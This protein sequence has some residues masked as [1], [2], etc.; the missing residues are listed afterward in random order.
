ME[1]YILVATETSLMN[2]ANDR[3]IIHSL[4]LDIIE[5]FKSG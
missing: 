2:R 5:L 3:T 4:G 1:V